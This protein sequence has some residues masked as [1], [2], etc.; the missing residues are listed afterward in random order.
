MIQKGRVIAP[1]DEEVHIKRIVTV[2]FI[3][4]IQ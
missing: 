2:F 4:F 3:Y 1:E